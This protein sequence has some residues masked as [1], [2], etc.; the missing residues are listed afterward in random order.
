MADVKACDRSNPN[1]C[2]YVLSSGVEPEDV[3]GLKISSMSSDQKKEFETQVLACRQLVGAWSDT[4]KVTDDCEQFFKS[5]TD[6]ISKNDGNATTAYSYLWKV[7]ERLVQA[8]YSRQSKRQVFWLSIWLLVAFVACASLLLSLK[9][10]P[11]WS[12]RVAA[13]YSNVVV[14]LSSFLFGAIGGVFDAASAMSAHYTE[15][16]F[17]PGHTLWYIFSPFLGGI[18]GVV[19]FA[20]AL[21]G[22]LTTTSAGFSGVTK[23]AT[24]AQN[25]IS[26]ASTNVSA[27]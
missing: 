22:L 21:A 11:G 10:L 8:W 3:T 1:Y 9:L 27:A 2:E 26:G 4:P 20:A 5:A 24:V 23:N 17:E 12:P 6:E 15:R 25:L 7:R 16:T 18:L 19:V 14:L 13:N